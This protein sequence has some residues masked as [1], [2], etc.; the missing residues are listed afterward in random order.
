[1]KS[2]LVNAAPRGA[3][4]SVSL[5]LLSAVAGS[6]L[7]IWQQSQPSPTGLTSPSARLQVLQPQ[8]YWLKAAG[9]RIYL[10]PQAKQAEPHMP[11]QALTKAL[12]ELLSGE[13]Q[14]QATTTIPPGTHLLALQVVQDRIYVNLSREFARGGGSTSMI[15]RTAQVLYTVTSLNPN[16]QLFLSVEGQRLDENHP[17]G[18]EGLM[19]R[20]PLTRASFAQDFSLL[21]L[22]PTHRRASSHGQPR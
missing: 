17:L 3:I 8:I 9:S 13:V 4:L 11:E 12:Q 10:S 19:L 6:G 7:W 14:P 15:Y 21:E 22:N 5:L 2:L 16:A 18:G 1:M 20:Q